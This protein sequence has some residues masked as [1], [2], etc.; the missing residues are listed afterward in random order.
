MARL[1]AEYD[2]SAT[3]YFRTIEKTF[4]PEIISEIEALGHEI[5]YHYEDMDRADGNR[6]RA[7][8]L[9]ADELKRVRKH[10]AVN[11]I[12]M[13]G[14]PLTAYDNRKMWT[15]EYGFEE[16]DLLGE[17]YHSMNFV[18]VTYFS[19]TGRTW[20]DGVFKIKD[21]TIGDAVKKTTAKSTRDFMDIIH[22]QRIQRLCIVSHPNRWA[23]S[24]VEYA[25]EYSKYCS[26]S[27]IVS[28][29]ETD[30]DT[31]ISELH[32]IVNNTDA[33]VLL[34]VKAAD[35]VVV[36]RHQNEFES[37]VVATDSFENIRLAHNKERAI[38]HA[39]KN[40]VPVPETYCPTTEAE[41]HQIATDIEY[42]TVIKLRKTSAAI[43]LRYVHSSEELLSTYSHNGSQGMAVDYSRPLIQEF[44]S[45]TIHDVCVLLEDGEIKTALTQER[46][47]MFPA[48]GGAGVV[49][50]TTDR[51]DLIQ[52]TKKLL[53]PL[54]WNGI[55]QVEFI[56][57]ETTADPKLIEIN[58]KVWGTTEL[59]IAAGVNFPEQLIDLHIGR[60][61][62]SAVSDYEQGL[63]FIWYEGGLLGNLYES[64]GILQPIRELNEVRQQY[65]K[66]NLDGDD[67]LP[68]LIRLP[69]LGSL[70]VQNLLKRW[71]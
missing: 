16:Y 8:E 23:D 41:L 11:T 71:T 31:F 61:I 48:S 69:Q 38:R 63:Y 56:E 43:G 54:D 52:Y 15:D 18:D 62:P 59:S 21:H 10:A 4:K 58:P 20:E 6:K 65:Y 7:H 22:E 44:V 24:F 45:G 33:D 40:G 51:K 60:P 3:Y 5:G 30:P 57:D 66:T 67:P 36:S 1:E 25:G 19:D 2:I 12:C 28:D 53:S 64:R 17:A 68:H 70:S 39:E 9:F 14:N 13:H 49:D 37:T 42:P 55:A 26:K 46:V 29:P 50:K 34:P 27:H 47:R 32:S 35:T